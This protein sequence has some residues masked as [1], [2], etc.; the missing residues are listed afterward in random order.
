MVREQ[1]LDGFAAV[2]FVV[3]EDHFAHCV[4]AV[5]L[6][7]H[8]L[9]AA[10]SDACRAERDRVLHLSRRVGV[11]ANLHLAGLGAPSHDLREV[12]VSATALGRGLVLE[13]ALDDFR[14]GGL[15]FARV[16]LSACSVDG[17]EIAFL[18]V[19]FADLHRSLGVVDLH[20]GSAANADFAHL[21]GD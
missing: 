12:F 4:D 2:G 1:F 10:Q 9:G 11:S 19:Q 16:N 17:E 18:E 15:D 13:Q 5:A 20:T 14:W 6:E 3:G 21:P 8:V 7:E